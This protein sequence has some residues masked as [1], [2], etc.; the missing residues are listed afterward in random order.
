MTV[1]EY[2]SGVVT[3]ELRACATTVAVDG[4]RSWKKKAIPSL[5]RNYV[6]THS[7]RMVSYPLETV[8]ILK[9]HFF[10]LATNNNNN[11]HKK[12]NYCW[13]LYSLS[14]SFYNSI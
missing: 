12:L 4:G 13:S 8:P 10:C 7:A 2:C 5:R 6:H 3:S 11:I 1:E 14:L 9:D